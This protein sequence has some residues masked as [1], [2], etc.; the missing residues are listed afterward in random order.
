MCFALELEAA[1]ARGFHVI[2]PPDRAPWT[3]DIHG[4]SMRLATS[5]KAG[6]LSQRF[7]VATYAAGG[8]GIDVRADLGTLNLSD[9]PKVFVETGNM[10]NAIDARMLE[11]AEFRGREAQALVAGLA[12]FLGR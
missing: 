12:R 3:A 8:D 5:V 6:L 7:G 9:V 2:A 4:P 1:G 11:Q 10:R